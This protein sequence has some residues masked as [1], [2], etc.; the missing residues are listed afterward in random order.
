MNIRRYLRENSDTRETYSI[1]EK[2]FLVAAGR[3]GRGRGGG[4]ARGRGGGY[5]GGGGAA[6]GLYGGGDCKFLEIF[7][8]LSFFTM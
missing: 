6:G 4:G 8:Y 7:I 5:G 2:H 3:G 1:S